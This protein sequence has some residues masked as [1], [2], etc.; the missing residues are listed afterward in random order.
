MVLFL[1]AWWL[2]AASRQEVTTGSTTLRIA[3][4][5]ALGQKRVSDVRA[6]VRAAAARTRPFGL[7]DKL[8]S[9]LNVARTTAPENRIRSGEVG[10]ECC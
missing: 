3:G 1:V 6:R 2:D 7:P 8:G 9:E 10:S 5:G 4:L